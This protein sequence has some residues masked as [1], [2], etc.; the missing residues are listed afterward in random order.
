M[1]AQLNRV[2]VI[3]AGG[4]GERFWP[5]SR[6][7]RP[8]QLLRLSNPTATMLEEAVERITPLCGATHVYVST[9]AK[10][11]PHIVAAGVIP[12]SQVLAEPIKRN[13][14]GALV[15]STAALFAQGCGP[16]TSVAILTADHRIAP[17][18]AFRACVEDALAIAET[19]G[20]LVTIGIRPDRPETGYGY[21]E[22]DLTAPRGAGFAALSFREKPDLATAEAFLAAGSFL[23]NS[24]MFFFT[25]REFVKALE[26]TQP[27]VRVALDRIAECLGTGDDNAAERHFEKI[28]SESIDYAVMER[29]QK[30]SVV[31]SRFDWDDLGA[32]DALERSMP[33]DAAGNVSEGAAILIDSEGN[34]VYND[35]PS[36]TVAILGMRDVI[37][38]STKDAVLV[39]PKSHA[40]RVKEIVQALAAT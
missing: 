36:K 20:G 33:L 4:S 16:E 23:W 7:D 24:G 15:W 38:V 8:K 11:A 29:A 21:I 26:E 39:C 13:T 25:L 6:P 17:P 34:V 14:L 10:L 2:A 37:V 3:M 12:A 35:D 1:D 9:S 27:E 18:A 31:P 32:W 30:V 5:L 28:K 22:A 40:Q 19:E